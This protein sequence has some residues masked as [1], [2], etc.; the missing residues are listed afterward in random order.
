SRPQASRTLNSCTVSDGPACATASAARRPEKTN[1]P[2]VRMHPPFSRSYVSGA[3]G[4]SVESSDR[5]C[6]ARPLRG[7]DD[8]TQGFG[9]VAGG[10]QDRKGHRIDGERRVEGGAL[11]LHEAVRR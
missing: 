8:E 9:P 3:G 1:P 5:S 6:H 11:L 7:G 2:K 4:G 10:S